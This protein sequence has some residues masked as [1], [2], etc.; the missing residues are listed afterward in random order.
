MKSYH[1]QLTKLSINS[2][3]LCKIISASYS[4]D[5]FVSND[6]I[7]IFLRRSGWFV[8]KPAPV[9]CFGLRSFR[10]GFFAEAG[11]FGA[12]FL[13]S[14][15]GVTGLGGSTGRFSS[16][17]NK[18][19]NL[20]FRGDCR[21]ARTFATL[22]T[23]DSLWVSGIRGSFL[24][25][26]LAS[27]RGEFGKL[28]VTLPICVRSLV[29]LKWKLCCIGV[30][31]LRPG[32]ISVEKLRSARDCLFCVS[33]PFGACICEI[34]L[35]FGSSDFGLCTFFCSMEILTE[36]A[37]TVVATGLFDSCEIGDMR[38]LRLSNGIVISEV[39]FCILRTKVC[40]DCIAL[41]GVIIGGT[42][43][44]GAVASGTT[45][46]R[47][48]SGTSTV[49]FVFC[50]L[51]GEDGRVCPPEV[52]SLTKNSRFAFLG[53]LL[54]RFR[55]S[56]LQKRMN[57]RADA[58]SVCRIASISGTKRWYHDVARRFRK[59]RRTFLDSSL[60]RARIFDDG[61]FFKWA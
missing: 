16:L 24:A 14:G 22:A 45:F 52:C 43:G 49:T 60:R 19:S 7:L 26:E 25:W 44:S 39:G 40:S 36:E 9:G 2:K 21:F 12:A 33:L 20:S 56:F 8:S 35:G 58:L 3:L 59:L 29:G 27:T 5:F 47:H 48:A 32:S 15:T 28:M 10:I 34:I 54:R 37:G 61:F 30:M 53:F 41:L 55:K 38:T 1:F 42:V 6:V 17:P 46:F 31:S 50:V 4:F 51:S 18:L 57:W 23:S 11:A 13:L